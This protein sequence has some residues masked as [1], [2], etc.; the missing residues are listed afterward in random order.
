MS[1]SIHISEILHEPVSLAPSRLTDVQ[2]RAEKLGDAVNYIIGNAHKGVDDVMKMTVG[3]CEEGGVG[4]VESCTAA[5][6]E[7]GE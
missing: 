6:V 2:R 4:D 7:A 5:L 3:T 1:L